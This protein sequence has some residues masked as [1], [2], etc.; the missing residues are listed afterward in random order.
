MLHF[1]VSF[2]PSTSL[3]RLVRHK[4]IRICS[5]RSSGRTDALTG[6]GANSTGCLHSQAGVAC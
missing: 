2:A 5:Q 4:A 6:S 1:A 3:S